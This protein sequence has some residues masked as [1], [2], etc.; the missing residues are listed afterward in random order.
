VFLS[1]P[2]GSIGRGKQVTVWLSERSPDWRLNMHNANLDLPVLIGHLLSA[3]PGARLRLATVVRGIEDRSAANDF[4]HRLID[5]GRL[6]PQTEIF[7]G[8]GDFLQAAAA[9]PY[10]DIHLFGLPTTI[11]KTRLIEIR[12]VCGGACVFLLDSGQ[13]S[14]LA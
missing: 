10:A 6:A 1:H 2:D 7:V 14:I 8:E 12:D 11:D 9:S 13:E 3:R 5:Q 4:L